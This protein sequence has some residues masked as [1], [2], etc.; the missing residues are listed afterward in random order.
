MEKKWRRVILFELGGDRKPAQ[1]V[2]L[3][4]RVSSG[5]MVAKSR[6]ALEA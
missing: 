6:V 4:V 3:P 5:E 1:Q 2:A